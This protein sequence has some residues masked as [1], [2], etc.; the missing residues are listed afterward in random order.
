MAGA[1]AAHS[2]YA[3]LT[4]DN[5]RTEDPQAILDEVEQGL[6]AAGWTRGQG[7]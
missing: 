2:D 6:V 1:A 7:V 5:P 3:I 4:S